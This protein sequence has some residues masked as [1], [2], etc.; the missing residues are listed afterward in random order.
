MPSGCRDALQM[1]TSSDSGRR[2]PSVSEAIEDAGFGPAQI[3]AGFLGGGTF[4]I[5]GASLLLAGSLSEPIAH[6]WH[7]AAWERAALM[8]AVF[9][10]MVLGNS[11]SGPLGDSFGRRD[12]IIASHILSFLTGLLC[13][14]AHSFSALC[15]WRFLLGAAMGLGVPP[16]MT[17]CTEITPAAWRV[18]TNAYSQSLFVF[19]EIYSALLILWTDSTM[20]HL[21]W[22]SLTAAGLLPAILLAVFAWLFLVQSPSYLATKGEHDQA[23]EVIAKIARQ[24]G[25]PAVPSELRQEAAAA[26]SDGSFNTQYQALF[27]KR[28]WFSTTTVIFTCFVLNLV[29]Y[30]VL[31]GL[32][33]VVENVETGTSPAVSL[34]LG[35]VWELPGLLAGAVFGTW[36]R[37][38]P[39]IYNVSALMACALA[40]F[41][42][43]VSLSHMWFSHYIIQGCLLMI[44][45]LSNTLFVVVYQ[46]A[47]ELYPATVRTTGSA[48]CVSGGRLGAILAPVFFEILADFTGGFS[49]FFLFTSVCVAVNAILALFLPFETSNMSLDGEME[50]TLAKEKI[51]A[52]RKLGLP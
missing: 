8:S 22:R 18:P 33:Q 29:F 51:A 15:V 24:N 36:F 35:A 42:I 16:W 44:K 52:A 37:R 7:L 39:I 49:A 12:M 41:G 31:Y 45:M 40:G 14:F 34:L 4:L 9:V 5:G 10:G 32:P 47:S 21:E 2:L 46:Y 26:D 3:I 13:V 38:L 20:R 43:G 23:R 30:G 28:M 48:I 6:E 11:S 19:G 1:A 27:G 17:L 25:R 50:P